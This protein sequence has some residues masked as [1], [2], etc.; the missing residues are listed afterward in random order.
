[1]RLACGPCETAGP[2]WLWAQ[3]RVEEATNARQIGRLG[4]D[5]FP[6]I[7]CHVGWR[8]QTWIPL[9]SIFC[10][11]RSDPSSTIMGIIKV[12]LTKRIS[13]LKKTKR[14]S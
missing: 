11:S 3:G 9:S 14:I 12:L 4:W 13:T 7:F 10:V 8:E 2:A 6:S 5:H 1:M